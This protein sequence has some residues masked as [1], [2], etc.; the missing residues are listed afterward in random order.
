MTPDYYYV[1]ERHGRLRPPRREVGL[2]LVG[3][4]GYF[5]NNTLNEILVFDPSLATGL[6]ALT[7]YAGKIWAL[8]VVVSAEAFLTSATER[9]VPDWTGTPTLV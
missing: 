6:Y 7:N 8:D 1:A 4:R 5:I 3:V 9:R 2:A